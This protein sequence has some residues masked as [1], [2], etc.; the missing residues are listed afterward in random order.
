MAIT[1]LS[2]IWAAVMITLIMTAVLTYL[3]VSAS[4][5]ASDEQWAAMIK[6]EK[7]EHEK[8]VDPGLK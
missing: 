7:E 1:V 4:S 6:E 3:A 2:L 8:L 5:R